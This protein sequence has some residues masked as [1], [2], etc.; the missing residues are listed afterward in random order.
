MKKYLELMRIKH[1]IKNI[2]IFIPIVFSRRIFEFDFFLDGLKTFILF[3]IG[4]SLIYIINDICDVEKDK[5]HPRK[6]KRVLASGVITIKRAIIFNFFLL[7]V[8]IIICCSVKKEVIIVVLLYIIMNIFYSIILKNI[9]IVDV[10]IIAFGFIL[11]VVAGG[12]AV[13][14]Y[15]SKWLILTIFSLALFLGFGKRKNEMLNKNFLE[16][17]KVLKSYN[18][19]SLDRFLSIFSTMF[20]VFYCLYSFEEIIP[21]FY[22]TI[23]F[24]IY[25]VLKYN[26]LLAKENIEGDPTEILLNDMGIRITCLIY[27]ILSLVLLYLG[28]G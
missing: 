4:S 10:F 14:V 25:G 28:V 15:L 23:P 8:F 26:L 11:R 7:I 22:L 16:Q 18:I 17:R 9:S 24:V 6:C 21:Y 13:E 1:W 19:D 27:I 2:F 12:I 3:S 20:L 5:K